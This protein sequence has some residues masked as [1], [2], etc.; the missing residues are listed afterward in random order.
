[1]M[2]SNARSLTLSLTHK[3]YLYKLQAYSGYFCGLILA[4]FLASVMLTG[5]TSTYSM[6]DPFV[7]LTLH[8]YSA[9]LV[10][11]FS[12]IWATVVSFIITGPRSKAAAFSLPGNRLSDCLSDDAYILTG[13]LF[14]AIT[15]ALFGAAFRLVLVVLFPGNVLAH[16]FYPVFSELVTIGAATFFYML[17]FSSAAYFA[18]TLVRISR[19][20]IIA[21]GAAAVF[22]IFA[23]NITGSLP[24]MKTIRESFL[25]GHYPGVFVCTSTAVSVVFF[26]LS[27]VIAQHMEVRR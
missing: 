23:L 15:T 20:F 4:Q 27:A 17:L 1:M 5:G 2:P 3:A 19:V 22:L 11:I 9:Q 8:T 14:G 26:S 12:V 24:I 21:V 16:G 7:K 25:F 18:G 10:Y 6:S 13:C